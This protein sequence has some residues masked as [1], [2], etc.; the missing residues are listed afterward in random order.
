MRLINATTLKLEKIPDSRRVKYAIL[1][2]SWDPDSEDEVTFQDMQDEAIAK[3]KSAYA[4][5]EES[6]K[7]ARKE[8]LDYV[9]IVTCCIDKSS[10]VELSEAINSIF[11][12]YEH[13]TIC[14]A[15]LADVNDSRSRSLS[16]EDFTKGRWLSRGWT[17]QELI[18]PPRLD[19]YDS[20]LT[21][22]ASRTDTDTSA[23]T[24][25]ATRI[26]EAYL[27]RPTDKQLLDM[28]SGASIAEY[29]CWA[30]RRETT[31][32]EDIAYCL[33]GI[34][35]VNMPLLYGEGKQAAFIRLQEEIIKYSDDQSLFA[36]APPSNDSRG[37]HDVILLAYITVGLRGVREPHSMP[38]WDPTFGLLD[39]KPGNTCHVA[40]AWGSRTT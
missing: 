17:L 33:L 6:C 36:W 35:V 2:H 19:F 24:S 27:N 16:T 34:F 8:N 26:D 37:D 20:K 9:W 18:A 10:S 39:K 4:K 22:F 14:Y 7:L 25:A 29:M 13:S 32:E 12:W 31:R 11:K 21:K 5:I 3:T 38:N 23:K 1:S 28:F 40:Y 30:S 15:Y